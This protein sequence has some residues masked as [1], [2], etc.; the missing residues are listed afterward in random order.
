MSPTT[1]SSIGPGIDPANPT[2]HAP[3]PVSTKLQIETVE[4]SGIVAV[5]SVAHKSIDTV[6]AAG[7]AAGWA[8]GSATCEITLFFYGGSEIG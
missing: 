8:T 5:P 7:I 2:V 1:A 4:P 6:A 3:P